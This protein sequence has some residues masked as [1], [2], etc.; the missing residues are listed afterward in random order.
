MPVIENPVLRGFHPD[1]S[2]LRVKDEF[3]LATSTFEWFPGVQVYHSTDLV[4]WNLAAR[5]L[6]RVSQLNLYGIP[7]SGGV[8]AP[9][10][11]YDNGLFYLVYT[12]TMVGV[13]GIGS[14]TAFKD[15][16]NFVVTAPS[17]SGP[18]S[19]PVYLNS[20]G[21]DPSLFHD[22]NGRKWLVNML[23]DYRTGKNQFAGIVLQEYDHEHQKLVGEIKNIFKGTDIG[24]TEGP[25]LYKRN[26]WYYLLTAEGGTSYEHAVTLA[27]SKKIDGPYELHPQN[28]IVTGVKD[29][30]GLK[31]AK[32]MGKDIGPYLHKGL[33]KA[34]HASIC[35]WKDNE[36]ILAHL[37]GRPLPGSLCCPL[38]RETALQKIIWRDDDWPYPVSEK[39]EMTVEFTG[40]KVERRTNKKYFTDFDEAEPPDEFQTLRVP[41]GEN[42]SLGKRKGYARLY[43]QESPVS[44]F[45]QTLIARRV[46]EFTFYAETCIEFSPK[47]YNTMAGLILRYD[48]NNQY[49]LRISK[50]DDN[51][52]SLGILVYDR[53]HFSMPVQQEPV[54]STDAVYLAVQ[55][56]YNKIQFFFS[57]DKTAWHAIG[58]V[59]ESKVLSDDYVVPMGFTGMFV[60][61][62]CHD[63]NGTKHYADFDYFLYE[64]TEKHKI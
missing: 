3:F 50:N 1:P 54:I 58:P 45:Q 61:I 33:Q 59:L 35:P 18:W 52:T 5:P 40:T 39:P 6:D 21:F 28:P 31:S 34:G 57:E 11:S 2:I 24:V 43:G 14:H 27:R 23:W 47:N 55:M 63:V 51:N 20:S 38:G 13:G 37:C 15:A 46:E 56:A 32:A 17:I 8:W 62:A 36:W 44:P 48:D 12:N 7:P 26:G 16:H 4:N 29:R 10:L 64:K 49:Y 42:I 19:E 22:D 41:L 30:E 60:G 25:H 53:R 9:C